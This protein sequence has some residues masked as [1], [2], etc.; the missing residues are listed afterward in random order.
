MEQE[1][2]GRKGNM[3][4]TP[5]LGDLYSCAHYP[6]ARKIY[7]VIDTDDD[8]VQYKR[9]GRGNYRTETLSG[10][11]FNKAFVFLEGQYD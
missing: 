4:R 8:F 11:N 1:T 2:F 5:K 6:N 9:F 10:Y 7:K 3:M